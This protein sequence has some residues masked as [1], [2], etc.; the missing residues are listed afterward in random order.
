[1]SWVSLAA[2]EASFLTAQ[3]QVVFDNPSPT[4]PPVDEP[5]PE[6]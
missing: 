3:Q 4:I 6:R 2:A 1:M 5:I